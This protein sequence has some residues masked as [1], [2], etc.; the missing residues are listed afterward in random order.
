MISAEA[1]GAI[2]QRRCACTCN[3]RFDPLAEL[4][5]AKLESGEDL[6][7]LLAV[8]TDGELVGRPVTDRL[9]PNGRR[10]R[11]SP[12]RIWT[13]TSNE[14]GP[15][16]ARRHGAAKATAMPARGRASSRRWPGGEV[17]DVRLSRRRRSTRSLTCKAIG[18]PRAGK[19]LKFGVGYGLP[20]PEVLPS[21]RKAG[22]VSGPGRAARS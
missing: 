17:D 3:S 11:P 15:R 1:S 6:G 9:D 18:R 20:W 5:A 16:A 19:P 13:R 22:C 12:A 10:S 4:F 7:A 2:M 8:D 14:A 21:C